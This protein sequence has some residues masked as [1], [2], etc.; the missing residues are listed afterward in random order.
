MN[1][2]KENQKVIFLTPTEEEELGKKNELTELIQPV[3]VSKYYEWI[4]GPHSILCFVILIG[5]F[6][7]LFRLGYVTDAPSNLVPFLFSCSFLIVWCTLF[8]P[9]SYFVQ[10]HPMFWKAVQGFG[11]CYMMLIA[12]LLFQDVDSARQ[13]LKNVDPRLGVKLPEREYAVDC[14][15]YTPEKECKWQNVKDILTDEFVIYH[16]VGWWA[17]TVI[18]RDLMLTAVNSVLFELMEL[19]FQHLLPNFHEC[20]WDHVIIDV[21][22]CNLL[23]MICGYY[24]LKLFELKPFNWSGV[25]KIKGAGVIYQVIGHFTPKTWTKYHWGMFS[26]WK[27]FIYVLI[28]IVFFQLFDLNSFFLKAVLWIQTFNLLN[29]YRLLI[30]GFLAPLALRQCYQFVVDKKTK[31]I[32]SASWI[33]G[34]TLLLELMLWLKWGYAD[35]K[36]IPTPSTVKWLWG[37]GLILFVSI[38]TVYFVRKEYNYIKV[39]TTKSEDFGSSEDINEYDHKKKNE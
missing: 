8:L 17:R 21:L 6:V 24:T 14:R 31:D 12:F 26:H 9:D 34:G 28:I 11:L 36:T 2:N 4:K 15:I 13:W 18:C 30:L 22:G 35:F 7:I 10:P 19:T 39:S 16:F 37:I 3:N 27:R 25:A 1:E 5:L 23:G 33:I 38:S 29:L 32:G 20:W